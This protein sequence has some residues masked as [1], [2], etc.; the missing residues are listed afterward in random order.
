M[1]EYDS[2]NV[3][4]GTLQK[5]EGLRAVRWIETQ[6][7]LRRQRG[8]SLALGR[9]TAVALSHRVDDA[10]ADRRS[11]STELYTLAPHQRGRVA[12]EP[13]CAPAIRDDGGRD[14]HRDDFRG[15][16]EPRDPERNAGRRAAGT[17]RHDDD[18][19]R[20]IEECL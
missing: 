20:R 3:H 4:V 13:Q 6:T 19:G 5:A 2:L 16:A 15:P 10:Q 18:V 8:G 12:R 1:P 9:D 11:R 7:V 17:Q 14:T